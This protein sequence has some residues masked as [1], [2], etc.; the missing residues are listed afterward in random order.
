MNSQDIV[1]SI[2]DLGEIQ[3]A[4]ASQEKALAAIAA[5][6]RA[7][8]EDAGYIVNFQNQFIDA[9]KAVDTLQARVHQE[10]A[11]W[12]DA[13]L[14][15]IDFQRNKYPEVIA[16]ARQ[17]VGKMSEFCEWQTGNI[18]RMSHELKQFLDD[19]ANQRPDQMRKQLDIIELHLQKLP[20]NW[21]KSQADINSRFS[22]IQGEIIAKLDATIEKNQQQNSKVHTLI[23]NM[24]TSH[25][26]FHEM[27]ESR[28]QA[29]DIS[30]SHQAG[31]LRTLI[32][33][34]NQ[35]T[36]LRRQLAAAKSH[37]WKLILALFFLSIVLLWVLLPSGSLNWP[38]VF[39]L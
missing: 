16:Q 34:A 2:H 11:Q 31:Q 8:N 32:D 38:W 9:L 1:I 4:L 28:F 35:S 21:K 6:L 7:F 17:T 27:I 20:D 12:R 24:I 37:Q 29:L 13:M 3:Q 39:Q 18:H 14:Q 25:D 15:M 30:A 36:L 10:S 5:H 33:L 22:Q 19:L 26:N 23:Q